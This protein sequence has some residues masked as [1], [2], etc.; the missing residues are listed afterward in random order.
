MT[1]SVESGHCLH[2]L[3]LIFNITCSK[4]GLK[5]CLSSPIELT[6]VS[7]FFFFFFFFLLVFSFFYILIQTLQ[8][9]SIAVHL[10]FCFCLATLC[11]V[12][13]KPLSNFFSVW[14]FCV[15][16]LSI[17]FAFCFCIHFFL[18]SVGLYAQ[19]AFCFC[20]T[21]LHIV[22]VWPFCVLFLSAH[23]A[24][25]FCMPTLYSVSV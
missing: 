12:S 19:F 5:S 1:N 11:S 17:H 24:F 23:F 4:M 7:C 9:P 21:T 8:S 15:L 20:L 10:V 16:F 18:H 25:C 2:C 14:P 13:V 22:S 6:H 3:P